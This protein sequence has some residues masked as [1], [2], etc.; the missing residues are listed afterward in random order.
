MTQI[1]SDKL[2]MI[3]SESKM[4]K[5]SERAS[6][7]TCVRVQARLAEC[8]HVLGASAPLPET[9]RGCSML[10]RFA[11]NARRKDGLVTLDS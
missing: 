8:T 11:G 4:E 7:P 1:P 10:V 3:D 9:M 2:K 6:V 5:W